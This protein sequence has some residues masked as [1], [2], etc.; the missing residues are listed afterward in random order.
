PPI[1]YHYRDASFCT[2]DLNCNDEFLG[3]T[4]RVSETEDYGFPHGGLRRIWRDYIDLDGDGMPERYV[5]HVTPS[6]D[7]PRV[8]ANGSLEHDFW[9]RRD[10]EA[11][12]L[13]KKIDNG[14]RGTVTFH[15]ARST[16]GSVVQYSDPTDPHAYSH[17]WPQYRAP[18]VHPL[19]WVVKSVDV[20]DGKWQ[21][22]PSTTTYVYADPVV[23]P[24]DATRFE[25]SRFRAFQ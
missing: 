10:D 19:I 9:V 8:D 5:L 11:P 16:D 18:S 13:L 2:S 7:N 12:S 21:D 4:A 14:R 23:A 1:P 15:Y 25:R 22:L 17:G 20:C 3:R 24:D 6:Q